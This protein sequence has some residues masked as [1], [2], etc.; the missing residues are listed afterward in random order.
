VGNDYENW[1]STKGFDPKTLREVRLSEFQFLCPG[2]CD[3]HIHAPQYAQIGLGMSVPLLD[4]LNTYTFPT[5]AKYV[6][7]EFALRIYRSVVVNILDKL[8]LLLVYLISYIY[9]ITLLTHTQITDNVLS[10]LL[11]VL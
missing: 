3:G 7:Q 5:E 11:N 1:L 10:D 4:W 8:D 9:V 2:F 6:D